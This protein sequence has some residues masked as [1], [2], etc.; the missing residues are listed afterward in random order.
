METENFAIQQYQSIFIFWKV[1]A[2]KNFNEFI[3]FFQSGLNL[4]Q[5]WHKFKNS[6][7]HGFLI[8]IMFQ[9]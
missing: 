1:K 7:F 5:L 8:Q 6:L 9:I 2:N 3:R 4:Q